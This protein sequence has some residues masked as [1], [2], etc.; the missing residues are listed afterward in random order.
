VQDVAENLSGK[1]KT[2]QERNF[3]RLLEENGLVQK[4]CT[5]IIR[6]SIMQKQNAIVSNGKSRISHI[7]KE[8]KGAHIKIEV[9]KHPDLLT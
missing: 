9:Q 8:R 3:F 7:K 5:V 1:A 6:S 4:N 2:E